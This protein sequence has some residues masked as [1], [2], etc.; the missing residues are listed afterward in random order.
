MLF[1]IGLV[2]AF[3]DILVAIILDNHGKGLSGNLEF[4][5][6]YIF[7]AGVSLMLASLC[8]LTWQYMP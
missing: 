5:I 4:L 2:I 7:W 1:T 6:M 3:V 8:I